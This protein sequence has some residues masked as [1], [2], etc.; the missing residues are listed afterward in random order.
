MWSSPPTPNFR[1]EFDQSGQDELNCVKQYEERRVPTQTTNVDACIADQNEFPG[2]P[3]FGRFHSPRRVADGG[4]P[5][6]AA[7]SRKRWVPRSRRP[8]CGP[9]TFRRLLLLRSPPPTLLLHRPEF[10][11]ADTCDLHRRGSS[12]RR[13]RVRTRARG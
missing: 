9:T 1:A 5:S 12:A 4:K 10:L 3:Y 2:R 7:S 11:K 13:E 6:P 8:F